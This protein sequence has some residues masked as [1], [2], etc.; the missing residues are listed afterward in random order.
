MPKW[1]GTWL[2]C[3]QAHPDSSTFLSAL[4][5]LL[6]DGGV[7]QD[8][9]SQ[10]AE[11][12]HPPWALGAAGWSCLEAGTDK[13]SSDAFCFFQ[14]APRWQLLS[15]GAG[16][17]DSRSRCCLA[18]G[19]EAF[20]P[21]DQPAAAAVLWAAGVF[22]WPFLTISEV[23]LLVT[24][25]CTCVLLRL[26]LHVTTSEWRVHLLFLF[27]KWGVHSDLLDPVSSSHLHTKS[28]AAWMW[29]KHLQNEWHHL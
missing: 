29:L 7:K 15:L 3:V 21:G 20:P 24:K 28:T 9:V 6:G 22:L 25:H 23:S 16:T 10:G 5:V 1:P 14:A 17:L 13:P 4:L 11:L 2:C 19:R 12:W 8:L 18:W 26:V 27:C